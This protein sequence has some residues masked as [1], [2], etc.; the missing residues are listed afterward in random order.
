MKVGLNPVAE[1]HVMKAYMLRGGILDF[2][3]IRDSGSNNMFVLRSTLSIFMVW[4]HHRFLP[5]P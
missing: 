2:G 5:N 4:G 1:F 3:L